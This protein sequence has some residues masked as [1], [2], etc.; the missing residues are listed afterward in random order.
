MYRFRGPKVNRIVLNLVYAD[1]IFYTA[2]GLVTPIVAVFYADYVKGGSIALAGLATAVFWVVK[3]A[4][5]VPVSLYADNHKG[6]RDDYKFIIIG[7]TISAV[8]PLC[9]YLFVTEAWHVYLMESLRGIGYGM[10]VPTYLSMF[11]RHIDRQRENFEWTLHSNAV[12]LGY[13]AAAALG[14]I[15]AER[16]GFGAIFLITSGLMFLAPVTLLFIKNDI[17]RSD[18]FRGVDPEVGMQHEKLP[19]HT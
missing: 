10:S 15:L 12:G 3:S 9:Y 11:T 2:V 8:V 1:L 14:G 6:E 13:A 5:Q 7:F 4:V 19:T 17:D 16:F 18:G